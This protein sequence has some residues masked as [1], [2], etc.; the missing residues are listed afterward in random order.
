LYCPQKFGGVANR[1]KLHC[2]SQRP[3]VGRIFETTEGSS[4]GDFGKAMFQGCILRPFH[5]H[6]IVV[7]GME[8]VTAE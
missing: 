1:N 4:I 3:A 2:P 8:N 6:A 5:R 7:D